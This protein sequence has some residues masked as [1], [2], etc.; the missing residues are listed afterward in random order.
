MVI[1]LVRVSVRPEQREKWRELVRSNAA[2]TRAED[3]CE[4]YEVTED[5][6]TPNTLSWSS[7][8]ATSMPSTTISATRSSRS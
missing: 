4:S 1:Q 8:G 6:E 5:T 7:G 3:G 2:Q